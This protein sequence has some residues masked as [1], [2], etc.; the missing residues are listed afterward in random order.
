MAGGG[1]LSVDAYLGAEIDARAIKTALDFG[2]IDMLQAKGA[3][4][5][6]RLSTARGVNPEGLRLLIDLLESNGVVVRSG[7]AVGLTSGFAAALRYRD[8]LEARIAFADLVWPDIHYLFSQL[9]NDLPQFTAKSVVFDLFRYDR[10]VSVTP[11]NLKATEAWTRFTT[12]LTRYEAEAVFERIEIASVRRFIDLGGNTGE[13]ALQFCRRNPDAEA[14]VVD[15]P[16]VCALGER[17]LAATAAAGE[18]SRIA[19]FPADMRTQALPPAGDFV[20]FK[21][22]LHDWPDADAERLLERAYPLVRPGGRL[23]IFER[24]PIELRGK[25]MTYAMAPDLVFL[26]YLR[27]ADLYLRKLAEFGFVAIEHRSVE[28]EVDF[29]LILAR[30]PQ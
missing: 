11:E 12:A 16:A 22:V 9:V 5:L 23:L 2:I 25:R 28:L 10:A 6:Q 13:F 21:S 1:F 8:L 4:S 17:H 27:P 3:T 7:E 30:R 24:A 29:H 18:A 14:V 20:A 19:F 26:H 15:L